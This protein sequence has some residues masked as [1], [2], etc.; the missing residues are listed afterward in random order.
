M[1]V[2]D[3][4]A[5]D[6]L[7]GHHGHDIRHI[8]VHRAGGHARGHGF[9]HDTRLP[10]VPS[11]DVADPDIAVGDH[12]DQPVRSIPID[13]RKHTDIAISHEARCIGE[14][15]LR[16]DAHRISRAALRAA[17]PRRLAVVP[18]I[19]RVL[20]AMSE[21]GDRLPASTVVY[22]L[23]AVG[24]VMYFAETAFGRL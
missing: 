22:A 23:A 12:T 4:N 19:K 21:F 6:A 17:R 3:R 10:F 11:G 16:R 8:G 2:D 24:A 13:D 7:A 1:V 20:I 14:Q 9:A 18:P 15:S 5:A